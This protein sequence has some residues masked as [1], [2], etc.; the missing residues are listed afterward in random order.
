MKS[1][2]ALRHA[3][4]SIHGTSRCESGGFGDWWQEEE[5]SGEER[6]AVD[7]I[8]EEEGSQG[9]KEVKS[10]HGERATD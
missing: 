9:T 1:D 3:N 8:D 5:K 4:G 2:P 10:G 7:E 6:A